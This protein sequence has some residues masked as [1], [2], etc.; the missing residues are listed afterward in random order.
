MALSVSCSD[1]QAC[2]DAHVVACRP[3]EFPRPGATPGFLGRV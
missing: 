3:E 1:R 2:N